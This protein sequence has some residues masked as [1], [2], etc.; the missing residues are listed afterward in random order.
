MLSGPTRILLASRFGVADRGRLSNQGK[1]VSPP[2]LVTSVPL[3]CPLPH[4]RRSDPPKDRG[5]KPLVLIRGVE[6]QLD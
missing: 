1:A 4:S 3:L 5:D 6:K 2:T